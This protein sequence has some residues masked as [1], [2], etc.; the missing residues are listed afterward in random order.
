MRIFPPTKIYVSKSDI[1]GYGVFASTFILGGEVIEECPIFDLI[2]T[3][4]SKNQLIFFK[5][6]NG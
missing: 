4:L 1:H 3:F 6:K 5:I 2:Q